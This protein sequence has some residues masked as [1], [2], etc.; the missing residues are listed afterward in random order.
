MSETVRQWAR[1][2]LTYAREA[3]TPRD[4]ARVM[5]VRLSQSKI[6]WLVCPSPIVV[7]VHLRSLGPDVRL[8]SH[9]TDISVLGELLVG[10]SYA[11]VPALAGGHVGSVVDLGANIGLTSRWMAQL[12]PGASLVCLE[13]EPGNVSSLRHNVL[14][15]GGAARVVEAC[16]GGRERRVRLASTTGEH[17][18]AMVEGAATGPEVD[19]ITMD[20]VLAQGGVGAIDVLKCDIEGAERE[21]FASCRSWIDRVGV[22]V[23][24]CHDGF[25]ADEL[26]GLLGANGARFELVEREVNPD[27]GCETVTLRRVSSSADA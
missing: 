17:G 4:F 2:V 12:W 3:R 21:L 5:R 16:V 13:P 24:E 22:A 26:I 11:R 20:H 25:G 19:V 8:R 9:T 23:V 18:F 27:Y 15:L 14:A 10:G 1:E 6:G 7:D